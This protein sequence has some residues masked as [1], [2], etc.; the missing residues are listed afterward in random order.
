V[1][2]ALNERFAKYLKIDNSELDPLPAVDCLLSL[3]IAKVAYCSTDDME[4]LL[5]ARNTQ[6]NS[7]FS[8]QYSRQCR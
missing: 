3:D 1:K 7:E 4:S 2:R 6:A 8:P 5:S